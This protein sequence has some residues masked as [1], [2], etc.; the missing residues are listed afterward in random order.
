MQGAGSHAAMPPSSEVSAVATHAL[1]CDFRAPASNIQLAEG[2]LVAYV[3]HTEPWKVKGTNRYHLLVKAGRQGEM[4]LPVDEKGWPG[5]ASACD[6]SP[7][8]LESLDTFDGPSFGPVKPG[9]RSGSQVLA[10]ALYCV[11]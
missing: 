1:A 8:V 6:V 5:L 2:T 10:C 3:A 9:P 7:G 11:G 4:W